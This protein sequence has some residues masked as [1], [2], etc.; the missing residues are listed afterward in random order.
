MERLVKDS[1]NDRYDLNSDLKNFVKKS[2]SNKNKEYTEEEKVS[3]EYIENSHN[4]TNIV[5]NSKT[6]KKEKNEIS[7]KNKKRTK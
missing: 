2:K 7:I 6:S 1:A 4:N 3:E 5:R